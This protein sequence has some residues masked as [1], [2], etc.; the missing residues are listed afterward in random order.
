MKNSTFR[1]Q[2]PRDHGAANNRNSYPVKKPEHEIEHKVSKNNKTVEHM[3]ARQAATKRQQLSLYAQ[4]T[5]D[6]GVK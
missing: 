6:L 4:V 1:S 5:L 2:Y 3:T